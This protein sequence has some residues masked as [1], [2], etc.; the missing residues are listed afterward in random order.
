MSDLENIAK[1]SIEGTWHA[2]FAILSNWN[3]ERKQTKHLR[4]ML[5]D[6]RF[7]FGRNLD[8]LSAPLGGDQ[9]LARRSLLAMGAR[10]SETNPNLWTLKSYPKQR[11]P[12]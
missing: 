7:P 12:E 4:K 2:I 6:S 8:Q 11:Q 3:N 9:D 5:S 10:P 1:G